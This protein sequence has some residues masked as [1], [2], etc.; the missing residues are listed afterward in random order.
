MECKEKYPCAFTYCCNHWNI[1]RMECKD[2]CICWILRHKGIGI[3]PE[4]NVKRHLQ[5]IK[6][7]E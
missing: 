3:Y 6:Q 7:Q 4:W 1:S 2:L 5:E